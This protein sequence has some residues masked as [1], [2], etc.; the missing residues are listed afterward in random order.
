M[1]TMTAEKKSDFS[2][3]KRNKSVAVQRHCLNGEAVYLF[4]IS[5]ARGNLPMQQ[6]D[7]LKNYIDAV[8]QRIIKVNTCSINGT[9]AEGLKIK[10]LQD[11]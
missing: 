7:F 8:Q 11:G 3:E 2:E 10:P 1:T 4:C 9:L 5:D 6:S